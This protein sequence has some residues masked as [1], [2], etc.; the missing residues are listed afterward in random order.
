MA[1]FPAA[2]LCAIF[3][4]GFGPGK[5][6]FGI[7]TFSL[8]LP[9]YLYAQKTWAMYGQLPLWLPYIFLGLPAI[10]SSN[11]ILFYPTNLIAI[12]S[13]LQP[14]LFFTLDIFFH[15]ALAFLG[16]F[17]LLKNRGI[18][19]KASYLGAFCFMLSG[20]L[21]TYVYNGHWLDIKALALAPFFMLFISRAVYSGK[22]TDYLC[23]GFI[24]G[25]QILALGM[26]VAAYTFI[27]GA[28]LAAFLVHEKKPS[29]KEAVKAF[30]ML[31]LAAIS[32]AVFSAAQFLPA[33]SYLPFSSRA[34]FS[35]ADFTSFSFHPIETITLLFPSFF[36]LKDAAYWG[37]A[38]GRALSFYC[39]LLPVLLVPPA[40]LGAQKRQALFFSVLAVFILILGFGGF[41]PL[42]KILY[43]I[44]VFNKLK[45]PSSAV[46]MLGIP[47][48]FLAALGA[49]N[50]LDC[51]VSEAGRRLMKTWALAAAGF[52]A[53]LFT[54]RLLG[55][56]S[57]H[58]VGFLFS[59][60]RGKATGYHMTSGELESSAALINGDFM[61][62]SLICA[63]FAVTVF[64]ASSKRIKNAAAVLLVLC[65]INAV[66]MY[67]V[68]KKFISY[69]KAD[70]IAPKSPAADYIKSA[71]IYRMADLGMRWHLN[72]N[73][74]YGI[75]SFLGF[76]GIMPGKI[77]K[78]LEGELK[79]TSPLM[80]VFNVKYY[81]DTE[82][83]SAHA[84]LG[85]KKV[86]D[87]NI[88]V[89]ADEKARARA[90]FCPNVMTCGSD[91]EMLALMSRDDFDTSFALVKKGEMPEIRG[92]AASFD[93]DITYY[94]ASRLRI[95]VVN[96][97]AGVL[98]VSNMGHENWKAYVDKKREKIYNVNYC[99][100]GIRLTP[101]RHDIEVS[102]DG[103]YI[104]ACMAVSLISAAA[105]FAF[106]ILRRKKQG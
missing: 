3:L 92:K 58:I 93:A 41:T 94:S 62:A 51:R 88:K 39:G 25:L 49:Q 86:F 99:L 83:T 102:Y 76:H 103:S 96:T 66:D 56:T 54:A 4:P 106:I 75:E 105:L 71:G 36:G 5:F 45:N 22:I 40:F 21:I 53:A 29:A 38:Q 63:V 67:R 100:Q 20:P 1:V 18:D 28:A 52:A 89:Y 101:G 15:C 30:G 72:R 34:S 90:Y 12:I 6:L 81:I 74:Y 48:S 73:M 82:E 19:E 8:H 44:P 35:Y 14:G 42:Y 64:I 70:D 47:L 79:A 50:M 10:D 98:V 46:A 26:Q 31:F 91:D 24:V 57:A 13:G 2:V 78:I 55:G 97:E 33:L 95:S 60:F 65:L 27:C 77:Y 85:L 104:Y 61:V 84:G 7:D 9:F 87:G 23:A 69:A 43:Y 68:E 16:M 59:A 11:L 37:P 32:A 17:L 80:R